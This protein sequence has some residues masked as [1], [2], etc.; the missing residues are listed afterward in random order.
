MAPSCSP[1]TISS[2][3]TRS[4]VDHGDGLVSMNFHVVDRGEGWRRVKRGQTLGK[5]GGN[6][7]RDRTAPASGRPLA[8]QAHR[9]GVAARIAGCVA[10]GRGFTGRAQRK[11]D[12]AET[13]EPPEKDDID[14]EG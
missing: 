6:R 11:I 7:A 13:R 4:I 3:A 2:P 5:I 1:P 8:R 12:K 14:D 10:V 9:S